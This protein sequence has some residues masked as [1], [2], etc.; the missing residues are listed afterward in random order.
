MWKPRRLTTLWDFRACYRDSFTVTSEGIRKGGKCWQ[1]IE[2]GRKER[3][4][5]KFHVL[6]H[7]RR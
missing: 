2:R 1:E 6:M 4:E 3:T 7:P 5:R